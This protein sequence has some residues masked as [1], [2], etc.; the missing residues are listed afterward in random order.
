MNNSKP[1]NSI[2]RPA[3]ITWQGD[4]PYSTSHEDLYF[5]RED[6]L[7]ESHY[8]FVSGNRI[9]ERL[10]RAPSNKPFVIAETG[11]G[12]GLNF[13]VTW[14]V[15]QQLP[16]PK[17]D[18]YYLS[19]EKHP[20]AR[21]EIRKAIGS[22]PELKPFLEKLIQ[23][24]PSAFPGHHSRVLEGGKLRLCL[25]FGDVHA[26]LPE[27]SFYADAWYL[28]GFA[29][30]K[31]PDMWTRELFHQMRLHSAPEASFS[32]FTAAGFVR[33]GLTDSGFN[34][35]KTKGFGSKREMLV[36]SLCSDT[37]GSLDS[38]GIALDETT[39]NHHD[40]ALWSEPA[41]KK[42]ASGINIEQKTGDFDVIVI[43]GGLAGLTSA[44]LLCEQGLSVALVDKGEL[45]SGASGQRQL[46]M[47]AKLPAEQNKE[48]RF[49][50]HS[51]SYSQS[52]FRRLQESMPDKKFWHETGLLQ[53][54]WSQAEKARQERFLRNVTLP[55]D[56]ARHVCERE[57]SKIS[58][59]ELSSSGLWFPNC[60]WLDPAAFSS[61]VRENYPIKIFTNTNITRIN[62]P[63][64][65]GF[66]LN[67]TCGDYM[68]KHVIVANANDLGSL[69]PEAYVPTKSLRG[70]VT[71]LAHPSLRSPKC[72]LCGEGY[73]CP[74]FNNVFHFGATYDLDNETNEAHKKDN[75][76]NLKSLKK[77]LP[78]WLRHHT[79]DVDQTTG[80][81]GLR[82]TTPDYHPIVGPVHDTNKM[83]EK[84]ASLRVDARSCDNQFGDY[85]E[86]LFINV[87]HGSKGLITTPLAAELLTAR[88]RKFPAPVGREQEHMLAPARFLVRDLIKKRI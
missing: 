53:L 43:G 74:E 16:S 35:K 5:S 22:W 70:Q 26:T 63:R 3:A 50:L 81:A 32:T 19:F 71:E 15:W 41:P 56:I 40:R 51:L 42:P 9:G 83:K 6:G 36:G 73:L 58:G 38:S 80:H 49:L 48:L 52:F 44:V 64:K 78:D 31:N 4:A 59:I 88:I 76:S 75:I 30:S 72:I 28:D 29:P 25:A 33:R 61:A 2:I 13:L 77:W 67:S 46:A 55:E 10:S 23:V 87:G 24:Y 17:P 85:I 37:Y 65:D 20:M 1:A 39:G 62:G 60:G 69:L 79:V 82:C 45:M 27:R 18:L 12:S 21:H 86:G 11:F 8:V 47:Y 84:F 14:K 68:A 54:A 57:A 34:V 7:E 66:E